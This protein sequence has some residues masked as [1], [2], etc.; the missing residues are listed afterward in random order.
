MTSQIINISE[1]FERTFGSKPYD[2]PRASQE[3]SH[4]SSFIIP[5]K[6][7]L[8]NFTAKGSLLSEQLL[9]VEILLPVKF[10]DAGALI[11]SLPYTVV[12]LSSKKTIIETALNDRLGT[13]KEEFSID[14]Y[15]I[16]VKGFLIGENRDF[17]EAQLTKLRELYETNHALT[18]DNALTNIFLTNPDLSEDEQRRVV[19]YDLDIQ[20][21]QG[22]RLHV[23]PF[24]MHLKS[25]SVFTLELEE[26]N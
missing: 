17:P 26:A 19:I 21:V 15:A 6:T 10:F 20:E 25:D 14:D 2:V 12:K 9:G 13:V 11:M 18:L 4:E 5:G 3:S 24:T 8:N 22:G 1:L 23:R 16:D 7:S